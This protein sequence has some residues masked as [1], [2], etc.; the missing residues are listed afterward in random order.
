MRS[1]NEEIFSNS[2]SRCAVIHKNAKFVKI[3]QEVDTKQLSKMEFETF[4]KNS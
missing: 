1:L 2:P 3:G 4:Q